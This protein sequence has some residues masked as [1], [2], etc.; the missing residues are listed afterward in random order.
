MTQKN[1]FALIIM[2][3]V[4][5]LTVWA[6]NKV[7]VPLSYHSSSVSVQ[8]IPGQPVPPAISTVQIDKDTVWIIDANSSF[9]KVIT[10]DESGFHIVGSE[11][12][13]QER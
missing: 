12:T 3:W 13:Y 5:V 4:T 11:M 7:V 6:V 9:I 1:V 2:I 8:G 10:H